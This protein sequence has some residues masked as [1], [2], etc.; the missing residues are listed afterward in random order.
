MLARLHRAGELTAVYV[1]DSQD[2]AMRDLSRAREDA[3]IATRKAKQRLNSFL[4][5]NGFIY[6]GR[7]KYTK[8]YLMI[9]CIHAPNFKEYIIL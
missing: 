8:A 2:E 1:P 6:S 3:V 9:Q 5:K 7:T 4:L